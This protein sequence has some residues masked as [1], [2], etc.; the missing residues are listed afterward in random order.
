MSEPTRIGLK[1]NSVTVIHNAERDQFDIESP[2][3]PS[4]QGRI[5]A[6]MVNQAW[7]MHPSHPSDGHP[8]V[9]FVNKHA[10]GMRCEAI[11]ENV[12]EQPAGTI[13]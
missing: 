2:D 9:A 12:P 4:A 6:E 3:D 1:F 13:N 10:A 8:V 7:L 5:I 11:V